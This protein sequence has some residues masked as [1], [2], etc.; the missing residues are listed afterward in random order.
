M[1]NDDAIIRRVAKNVLFNCATDHQKNLINTNWDAR[2]RTLKMP[3]KLGPVIT[4]LTSTFNHTPL[5]TIDVWKHA[6]IRKNSFLYNNH[7]SEVIIPLIGNHFGEK[8]IDLL[9]MALKMLMF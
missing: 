7:P 5:N 4:K 8:S 1:W 9:I 6:I 2:Y 3:K